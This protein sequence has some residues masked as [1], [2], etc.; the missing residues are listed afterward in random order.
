MALGEARAPA[1]AGSVYESVALWLKRRR[2]LAAAAAAAA[3]A[4]FGRM[5]RRA[6]DRVASSSSS[7]TR[8]RLR[9]ISL[10]ILVRL[11]HTAGWVHGHNL[12]LVKAQHGALTRAWSFLIFVNAKRRQRH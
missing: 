1:I 12:P 10:D 2:G 8:A 5:V 6:R 7:A 9:F 11:F 3:A 4:G